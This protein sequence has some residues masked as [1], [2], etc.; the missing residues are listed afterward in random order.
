MGAPHPTKLPKILLPRPLQ[1]GILR[2]PASLLRTAMLVTQGNEI[3]I[4]LQNHSRLYWVQKVSN[5]HHLIYNGLG[6]S[7][8]LCHQSRLYGFHLLHNVLE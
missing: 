6:L 3:I 4:R 8:R 2:T 1:P 5:F 7:I